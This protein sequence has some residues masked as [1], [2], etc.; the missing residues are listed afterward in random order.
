MDGNKSILRYVFSF[1]EKKEGVP[2]LGMG[3]GKS[4]PMVTQ[5]VTKL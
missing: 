5:K 3:R 4:N 1:Q 2:W